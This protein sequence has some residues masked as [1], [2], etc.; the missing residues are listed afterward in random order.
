MTSQSNQSVLKQF[1]KYVSPNVLGMIGFSCYI[2]A[3]TFFIAQ[4]VGQVGLS[5]LNFALP[6]FSIIS[7]CGLMFGIGGATRYSIGKS[8]GKKG[9]D[10]KALTHSLLLGGIASIILLCVA[11]FFAR[12]VAGMLGA[13][14][15]M[16]DTTTLYLRTFMMF[17]P[18]FITNNTMVSFVR[19]D[20]D[21]NL[22]MIAMLL[23]S[24]SNI[25][26]DYVL[27]FPL[28]MGIF[29]AALATGIAPI[30]SLCVVSSH[31]FKKTN[32]LHFT[33]CKIKIKSLIDTV[34]FGFSSFISEIAWGV[35]LFTFNYVILKLSGNVG[36]AA[37]SIVANISLVAISVFTGMSQGIQPLASSWFAYKDSK[38]I[39]KLMTISVITAF[40][41]SAVIYFAIFITTD[42]IVSLFNSENNEMLREL[43]TKGMDLYFIGLFFSGINVITAAFLSAIAKPKAAFVISTMRSFI[44][45][46]P[47]VLLLSTV[48]KMTGVWLSYPITELLVLL[49][50]SFYLFTTFKNID[51]IFEQ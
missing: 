6:M 48:L 20:N 3:D 18:F 51:K 22:A 24:L 26:L 5:A 13:D 46:I 33:K 38:R 9:G 49:I 11:I 12:P 39:R 40:L 19:N 8:E 43:A 35:T 16:I 7:G 30:I 4:S 23:S 1:L 34:L 29:G 10:N 45:I 17:T 21:P 44:V 50:S 15:N 14:D 28:N 27:M 31:F 2:L 42:N 25:I 47:A 36:V 37:Y 41:T 32:N